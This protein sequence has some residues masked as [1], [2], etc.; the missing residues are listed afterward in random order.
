MPGAH[1]P[2]RTPSSLPTVARRNSAFHGAR[3]VTT[4]KRP[5]K[6]RGEGALIAHP[7]YLPLHVPVYCSAQAPGVLQMLFILLPFSALALHVTVVR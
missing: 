6:G 1:S 4:C 5:V 2:Q 3:L 7:Q